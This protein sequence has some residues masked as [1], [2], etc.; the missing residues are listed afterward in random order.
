MVLIASVALSLS[1]MVSNNLYIYLAK[2][3][4][5]HYIDIILKQS[6]AT[7]DHISQQRTIKFPS[8]LIPCT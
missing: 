6:T 4:P 2:K 8:I 1:I 7:V 5:L 3:R